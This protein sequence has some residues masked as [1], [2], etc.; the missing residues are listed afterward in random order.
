[1]FTCNISKKDRYTRVIIG[2]LF[3]VGIGFGWSSTFFIV[4]SVLMIVEGLIGWCA[5]GVLLDKLKIR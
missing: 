1:M 3:L 4:L 5:L 2:L